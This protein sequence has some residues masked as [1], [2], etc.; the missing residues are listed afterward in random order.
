MNKEQL[1]SLAK[2]TDKELWK[3]IRAIAK[4][5]GFMLPEATPKHEDI[6]K[7]RETL[8]GTKKINLQEATK[9]INAYKKDKQP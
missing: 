9:I 8:L 3:E 2:K 5:H 6:E 7:I 4:N 1:S